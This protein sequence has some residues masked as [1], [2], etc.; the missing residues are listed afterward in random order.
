MERWLKVRDF[1]LDEI[2]LLAI[3]LVAICE[4]DLISTL[5]GLEIGCSEANP[6]MNFILGHGGTILFIVVKSLTVI[7]IIIVLELS[8]AIISK[9]RYR[10]YYLISIILYLGVWGIGFMIV[11]F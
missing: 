6:L 1:L 7:F 5:T 3:V 2:N 8:K 4:I 10:N 11:N 9:Q